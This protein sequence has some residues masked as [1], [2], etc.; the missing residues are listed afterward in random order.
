MR[1]LMF[2]MKPLN[3]IAAAEI[4]YSFSLLPEKAGHCFGFAS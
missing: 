3:E 2:L 1:A 4:R